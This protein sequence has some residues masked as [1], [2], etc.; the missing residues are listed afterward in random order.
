MLQRRKR[1]EEEDE[2]VHGP[3]SGQE[4]GV[5]TIN[6]NCFDL[7]TTKSPTDFLHSMA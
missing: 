5:P 7:T 3:V 4:E 1:K 6:M 2:E